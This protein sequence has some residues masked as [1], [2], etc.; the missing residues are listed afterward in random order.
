MPQ[1]APPDAPHVVIVDGTN[2]LYRAFFAIPGLR[3]PDGTPT[4][5]AYGFVNMLGKVLRE[6]R[7]DRVIVVFD[8]RG[9]TFRHRIYDAY[10]AH[11]D[12]QPEDLSAQIPLV[13]ELVEAHRIPIIEVEGFEA[14][15]VIATLVRRTPG[16]ARISIVSTDKDLMQLVDDRVALLDGIRERRYGPEEVEARFGVPPE[17][18]LDLRALVGDPSDNI[19]GVKGIGEKGA[20]K[21]ILEWGDLETLLAHADEVAAKRARSALKEGADSARLSKR[22][23]TLRTDAPL[24]LDPEA[25]APPE[26]DR[27]RLRE[28]FARLGF[29]RLLEALG[30]VAQAPEEARSSGELLVEC[31]SEADALAALGE[32]VRA[33]P[34][35]P[36][37]AVVDGEGS[38]ACRPVGFAL[39][40]A[41]ARAAYVPLAPLGPAFEAL[42][43]ALRPALAAPG[44]VAWL[45]PDAKRMQGIFAERG[46]ELGLPCFDVELAGQL[47]DARGA[48]GV[49]AL[50]AQHLGRTLG[51][52]EEL[53]GRGA[54]AKAASELPVDDVARWA[55]EQACAAQ[56]LV[57]PLARQLEEAGLSA[58][59]DEVELPLTRVLARME[60]VGVRVDEAALELLSS[61]YE[62]ELARIEREIHALAGEAFLI[63][64]PK[65]LQQI[66]F[67]KLKLPVVRKTKT[68]YSTD[69]GVLEQLAAQHELPARI[70][71]YRRLAKLK[72]TYVDAL[73]RLVNETT[74]RIHPTYNQLGAATG[75][76]SAANPNVQNIPIRSEEGVRI[77]EAFVP[78]EGCRLVSADYSQVELRI[79]AHYSG[80]ES[81]IEAFRRNE[82]IH[83]RT[84]AEVWSVT[85]EDVT[86]EQRARAKAVNFGIIYGLSSFGLANQL[87][88]AA[89][90]AQATIE[91]YFER[92]R[93]VRR[94]LDETVA[95]AKREGYV[96]TLL[97]RRRA[98]PDLN[99]RNRVLRQAAERM[100]VNT[101]IQGTAA[102]L[103]KKAMLAVDAALEAARRRARMILQVHDEL[104]LEVPEREVEPV[105][106]LLRERMENVFPLG[107]PLRVDVGSGRNWREAH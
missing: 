39:A 27:E 49:A 91:T 2:T 20:A 52:W 11:R 9:E 36:L 88:I 70:L 63:S 24:P 83:R 12:A 100:A 54:K 68:G 29:T 13:R 74:G 77:R 95:R 21:L 66:L 37:V 56:A 93:G 41:P 25:L 59:Y 101:V 50:A 51:S 22:L 105:S 16:A 98:L 53:A 87:G 17:Q 86:P 102:D 38:V 76:L 33:L 47:L 8:A 34:R 103:I 30:G 44:N 61:E 67:E 107:V 82:D 46:L 84:A 92:Y 31:V 35:L 64:S 85:P 4:N 80:D 65:Q 32:R 3:A 69:E 58:L 45:A 75:R 57:E 19:P 40:L 79:L 43:E 73:P 23:A 97:G 48:R 1:S 42:I 18:I 60:R 71:A 106:E 99:S 28:I 5:A 7:P 55:A 62:S 6:Q 15:D 72:N 10:K 104:V 96:R 26:P 78:A 90:E 14:D 89:A 81:L 94:F